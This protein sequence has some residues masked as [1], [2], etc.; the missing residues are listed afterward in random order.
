M[1]GQYGVL[2]HWPLLIIFNYISWDAADEGAGNTTASSGSDYLEPFELPIEW[3]ADGSWNGRICGDNSCIVLIAVY[4]SLDVLV[5]IFVLFGILL[6]SPLFVSAAGM[7]IIPVGIIVDYVTQPG[8]VISPWSFVGCALV[9]AGFFALELVTLLRCCKAEHHYHR[10]WTRCKGCCHCEN[11][12]SLV[13]SSVTAN[14]S[15]K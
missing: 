9:V 14:S 2:L 12:V 11:H 5:N 13:S 3:Q 8:L 4:C 6:S 7:F 10:F 1:M 15:G